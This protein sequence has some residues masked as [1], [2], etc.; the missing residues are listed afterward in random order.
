VGSV[1]IL[2]LI[3]FYLLERVRG[4]G[5]VG[6]LA[7]LGEIAISIML[8]SLLPG[9]NRF[10]VRI[11]YY[12]R[13]WVHTLYPTL[14]WFYGNLILYCVLPPPRTMSVL[15]VGFSILYI[16]FSLS[17]LVWKVILVYLSIRFSSRV[18]LYRIMYY[19]LLYL[20]LCVPLWIFLY[21]IG[22]S[23]IPFV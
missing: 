4:G 9:K 16:A 2:V 10:S 15:G 18:Q 12:F 14:L 23:R 13:T 17:L 20:A 21:H 7:S 1:I 5:G 8:L 19:F 6:F 22:I 11:H 3:Y